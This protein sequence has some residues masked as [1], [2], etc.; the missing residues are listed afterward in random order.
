MM[1]MRQS[2]VLIVE[3]VPSTANKKGLMTTLW[4]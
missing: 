2:R 4:Q 3:G 1:E